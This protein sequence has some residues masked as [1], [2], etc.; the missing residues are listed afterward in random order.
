M[1][2]FITPSTPLIIVKH[3]T[4][5][6]YQIQTAG[7]CCNHRTVEGFILPTPYIKES[8]LYFLEMVGFLDTDI[9][10][11]DMQHLEK[12]LSRML[13]ADVKHDPTGV[14]E[15]AFVTFKASNYSPLL[16]SELGPDF[17]FVLVWGNSD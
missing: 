7:Y 8:Y 9:S 11:E 2:L 12:Y 10:T 5:I 6:V 4:G 13:C 14:V 3:D 16:E 1:L 15:E 17:E